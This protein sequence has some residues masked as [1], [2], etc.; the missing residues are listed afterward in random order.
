MTESVH[1]ETVNEAYGNTNAPK[2]GSAGSDGGKQA[3]ERP[4]LNLIPR[5]QP[6]EH[7]EVNAKRDRYAMLLTV[8]SRLWAFY[9]LV[10]AI[11][12]WY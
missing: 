1:V 9:L 7:L 3:V 10:L 11:F 8:F 5:S 6:L 12:F 2:P 4:K